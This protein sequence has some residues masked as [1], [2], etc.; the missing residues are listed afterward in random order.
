MKQKLMNW[1]PDAADNVLVFSLGA[2]FGA[3]KYL[4]DITALNVGGFDWQHLFQ[5][6]IYAVVFGAA[7]MAGKDIYKRVRKYIRY[8]RRKKKLNEKNIG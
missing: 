2:L 5:G 1:Q 4:L 3:G 8:R 6:A 7:S